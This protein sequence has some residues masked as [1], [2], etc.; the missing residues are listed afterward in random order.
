MKK[1]KKNH[2][3]NYRII[4]ITSTGLRMV[5][6]KLKPLSPT[7]YTHLVIRLLKQ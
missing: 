1:M 3:Y 5:D 2:L 4:I 6:N 7:D